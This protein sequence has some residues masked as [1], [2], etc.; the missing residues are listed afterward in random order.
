MDLTTIYYFLDDFYCNLSL[1]PPQDL[2]IRSRGL[3]QRTTS[4]SPSELMA[5][6]IM[7]HRSGG[8]RNFKDYCTEQFLGHWHPEFPDAPNFSRVI[9]LLP[10]VL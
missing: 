6:L 1:E 5:I 3:H 8:C 9:Q 2:L 10:R 4:L 7:F